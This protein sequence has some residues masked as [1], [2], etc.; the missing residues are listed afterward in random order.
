[1]IEHPAIAAFLVALTVTVHFFGP[2]A[3][4]WVLSSR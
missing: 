3:L 1:M 4:L 2:M